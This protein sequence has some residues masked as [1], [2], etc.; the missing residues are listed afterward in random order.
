MVNDMRNAGRKSTGKVAR[1]S[2]DC[3]QAIVTLARA[4][5]RCKPILVWRAAFVH[6]VVLG[7]RQIRAVGT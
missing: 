3:F 5:K 6:E 2:G 1:L 4:L 7:R